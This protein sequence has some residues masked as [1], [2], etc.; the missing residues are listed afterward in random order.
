MTKDSLGLLFLDKLLKILVG[1]IE[2][3]PVCRLGGQTATAC[4]R[5]LCPEVMDVGGAKFNGDSDDLRIL[6][7][8]LLSERLS[9]IFS[10][11]MAHESHCHMLKV[12]WQID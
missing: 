6:A 2:S 9:N 10:R 8:F 5:G 4:C 3:F 1:F 12:Q 7:I 11:N